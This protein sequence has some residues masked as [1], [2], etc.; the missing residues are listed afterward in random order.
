MSNIVGISFA[1]IAATRSD[2]L[3]S[4][5]DT[6]IAAEAA[7]L[8]PAVK[9]L[10]GFFV[11]RQFMMVQWGLMNVKRLVLSIIR[12]AVVSLLLTH[13][14]QFDQWV[15]TPLFTTI[16]QAIASWVGTS[17]GASGGQSLAVQL[18][19][20]SAAADAMTAHAQGLN[21]AFIMG[22]TAMGR[23]FA[24][25]LADTGMQIMLGLMAFVWLLGQTFLA[26][27][28]CF[29]PLVLPLELFD[30]TRGFVDTWIGKLV[31]MTAFS[32]GVSMILAIEMQ[33]LLSTMQQVDSGM[34]GN[35][36]GAVASMLHTMVGILVDALTMI[37]LPG[38]VGFGSG[39][40]AGIAA[41]AA[42]AVGRAAAGV[43]TV[44]KIAASSA[45][46]GGGATRPGRNSI[47]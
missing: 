3:Q 47:T 12:M 46:G 44:G 17:S 19:N 15:R 25:N 8:S 20:A 5:M 42:F 39:V 6:I 41:P 26:I 21:A 14:N 18:D 24:I 34:G 22:P 9:G 28:I 23:E 29:G 36:A 11:A 35:V 40:A 10:F 32:I 7:M 45:K 37:A 16:P 38:I 13:T 4:T 43:G 33:G 30:R 31:G 1:A 2:Q 27:V